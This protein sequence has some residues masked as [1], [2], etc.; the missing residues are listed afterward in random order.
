MRAGAVSPRVKQPQIIE[1]ENIVMYDVDDTLVMWE[2]GSTSAR[3]VVVIDPYDGKP[4][5]L[6]M[7][8]PHVKL[9]QRH[10][11]RGKFVIV[12]S[13]GGYQWAQAV[14][15]ALGLNESVDLIMSKPRSY[16]D[17]LPV[18]EWMKDRIYISPDSNWGTGLGE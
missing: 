13:Q 9:L 12:W 8:E 3:E 17:D 15:N 1:S 2:Q 7:H 18:T 11:A 4:V 5:Y 16:V 10:K 14:V 6:R